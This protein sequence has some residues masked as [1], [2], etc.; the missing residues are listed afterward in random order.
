MT[1]QGGRTNANCAHHSH[2]PHVG[3]LSTY[4]KSLRLCGATHLAPEGWPSENPIVLDL[5]NHDSSTL[6]TVLVDVHM[7]EELGPST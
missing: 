5:D 6:K 2:S 3:D 7:F 4:E 1:R